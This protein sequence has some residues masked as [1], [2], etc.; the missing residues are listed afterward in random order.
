[1]NDSSLLQH[2]ASSMVTSYWWLAGACCF[3]LQVQ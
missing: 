3:H 2:D 1:M